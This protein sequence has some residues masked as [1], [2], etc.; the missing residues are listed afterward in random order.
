M[1]LLTLSWKNLVHK[2]LSLLLSL[3]LFALGTGLISLLVNLN[4]QVSRNFEKNLAGVDLVIG[5]KG[6]PLQLI[7]CSM[8]H[9]DNP[10]GNI[11][12]EAA[13]P[14]L[15]PRNPLVSQA[16]PLSLGDSHRGYRVVGT[17]WDILALYGAE[18]AEGDLWKE[19][20]EVT[21]GAGVARNLQL[22][23]G[24]RFRSSHGLVEGLEEHEHDF[25]VV[26]ILKPTGS[27]IDQLMLTP[28]E[29]IWLSHDHSSQESSGEDGADIDD[30]EGHDHGCHD[31]GC[32]GAEEVRR[33]AYDSS[34]IVAGGMA[35][36]QRLMA[37]KGRD[38]TAVLVRFRSRTNIQALNLGRN[39][40]QQTGMMAASPPNEIARLQTNLG[41]GTE[42]LKVMA[43]V[44]VFVS[45]LSIFI[46]LYSSLRDRA[47]ELAL[48]RVMGSSPG[49]LFRLIVMEGLLMA[50]TGYAIG[51][52]LSHT[53]LVVLSAILSE[54]YR[55]QFS[56]WIILPEEVM[57]GLGALVVGGLAAI[58]PAWQASRT[59]I[60]ETL[61]QEG[62]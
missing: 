51:L 41:V 11:S 62:R 43:W 12:L 8:Y 10:T 27:V 18:L 9:V 21:I 22:A 34:T 13:G 20:M 3:L 33:M 38:I 39:I 35:A 29:S 15:N 42:V 37:E 2:P 19:P 53:G 60:S 58:L 26:G 32:H 5:A 52:A 23:P 61:G 4:H 46:S 50:A 47:Y 56:A 30:H 25:V 28:T 44:I 55:Y 45:G 6:S 57:L 40:N 17:T 31:H 7:L 14:F 16:V 1:N 48:M 24:D 36:R 49:K 54:S 59:D